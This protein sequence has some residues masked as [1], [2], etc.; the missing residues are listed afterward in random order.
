M[1]AEVF[2]G[3]LAASMAASPALAGPAG[4]VA[5]NEQAVDLHVGVDASVLTTDVGYRV[6]MPKQSTPIPLVVGLS[7]AMPVFVGPA[8]HRLVPEVAT[9]FDLGGTWRATLAL[10]PITWT[11]AINDVHRLASLGSGLDLGVGHMGEKWAVLGTAGIDWAWSTHIRHEDL[12]RELVYADVQDG[13]YRNTGANLA[14]GV[15]TT[16]RTKP[17]DV[18]LDIAMVRTLGFDRLLFVPGAQA[19]VGVTRRW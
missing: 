4:W 9:R 13:W 6:A 15:S 10:Q 16:R 8:D 11:R 17:V 18:H 19:T 5:A 7:A 3:A 1:R 2:I 14:L 12:Y